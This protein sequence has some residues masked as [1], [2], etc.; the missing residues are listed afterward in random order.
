MVIARQAELVAKWLLVGFIHGAMNTDNM[1]IA[2]E[3]IDY[4][5][6]AFMDAFS[7]GTVYSSIDT[8]GRYA[9]GNQPRIAQW[10]LARLA[11]TLLPL[12]AEDK[13]AAVNEAQG[14]IGAFAT[15]FETA[16][17]GAAAA[18]TYEAF[19]PN[20]GQLATLRRV[21]NEAVEIFGPVTHACAPMS[22]A[23]TARLEFE[24]KKSVA[25]FMVAGSLK[26]GGKW[27]YGNGRP[28]DGKAVFGKL[29]SVMGRP[30][31][32]DVR[33]LR[34]GWVGEANCVVWQIGSV[35]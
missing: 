12:P 23:Y 20:E 25:V 18:K 31:M 3:T 22:A 27:I 2:G 10:N 26:V 29:Q 16:S 6:C 34:R 8:M 21:G 11:E 30:R 13:N 17:H 32:G 5:A 24:L 4:G 7:P 9:Y 35:A 28:F 14:A 15:R 1:S 33:P 19:H